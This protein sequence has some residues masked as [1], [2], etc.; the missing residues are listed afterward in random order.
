MS[1]SERWM[2]PVLHHGVEARMDGRNNPTRVMVFLNENGVIEWGPT[3]EP[4]TEDGL[5]H[6]FHF[7]VHAGTDTERLD[8]INLLGPKLLEAGH[9]WEVIPVPVGGEPG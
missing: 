3:G 4:G 2:G 9:S 7:W 6:S 8:A 1:T 5:K